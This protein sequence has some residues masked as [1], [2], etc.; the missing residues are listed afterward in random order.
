MYLEVIYQMLQYHLVYQGNGKGPSKN[1]NM[2]TSVQSIHIWE[3]GKFLWPKKLI[4]IYFQHFKL[5][6]TILMAMYG[7]DNMFMCTP[8]EGVGNLK[9]CMFFTLVKPLTILDGPLK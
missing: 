8:F 5:V 2:F 3:W 7:F 6:F 1:V 4:S 9:K